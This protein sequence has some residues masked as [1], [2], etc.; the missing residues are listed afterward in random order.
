LYFGAYA[1]DDSTLVPADGGAVGGIHFEDWLA[2]QL[3][4]A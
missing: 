1:V 3:A 4:A 2:Q